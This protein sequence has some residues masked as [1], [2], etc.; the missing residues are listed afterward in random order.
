MTRADAFVNFTYAVTLAAP[1]AALLGVRLARQQR[2]ELHRR[3]QLALLLVCWVAVLVLE[4]RIRLEGGSG[5]FIRSAAP[6][7]QPWARGLLLVHIGF[8][9]LSYLLWTW[10]VVASWRRF[11]K[12]LPGSFSRLHRRLGWA[13]FAGLVF[14]AASA[15]GM[16]LMTFVL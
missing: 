1:W 2:H 7:L 13:V 9:V 6:E 8:A 10:L 12:A 16:Y 3:V 15:T 14:D 5:S 4:V 11:S